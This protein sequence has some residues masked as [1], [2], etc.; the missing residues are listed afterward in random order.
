M[1]GNKIPIVISF[2]ERRGVRKRDERSWKRR[3][4]IFDLL[5][6]DKRHKIF[7]MIVILIGILYISESLF[8]FP[9]I[10][11]NEAFDIPS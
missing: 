8:V 11:W 1:P 3:S 7:E 2:W 10:W 6:V 4:K 9:L 5:L